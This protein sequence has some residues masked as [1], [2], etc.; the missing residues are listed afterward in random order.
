MTILVQ[1]M[2]SAHTHGLRAVAV[3]VVT[4]DSSDENRDMIQTLSL[5]GEISTP[6]AYG[7]K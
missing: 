5:S 2:I 6:P 1:I 4:V 7:E 3:V